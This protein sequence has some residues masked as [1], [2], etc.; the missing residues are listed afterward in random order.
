VYINNAPQYL[1][2]KSA[3][4]IIM[5]YQSWKNICDQRCE[6]RYAGFTLALRR[7]FTP[8]LSR[9]KK[10]LCDIFFN[11]DYCTGRSRVVA[12]ADNTEALRAKDVNN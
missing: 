12:E 5:G 7:R 2:S 11:S 9:Q 10:N 6:R 8:E 4:A 3:D 1:L